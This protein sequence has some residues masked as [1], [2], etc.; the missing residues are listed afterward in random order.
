MLAEA[1]YRRLGVPRDRLPLIIPTMHPR[2][3]RCPR[4]WGLVVVVK[5]GAFRE[6]NILV[7][8]GITSRAIITSR[9][10]SL[11]GRR[12][13]SCTRFAP[14]VGDIPMAS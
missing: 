9:A 13:V 14:I 11:H 5:G 7:T 8:Y 12:G 1:A 3:R 10:C 2:H 6:Y 4:R